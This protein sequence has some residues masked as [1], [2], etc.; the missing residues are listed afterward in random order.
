M[1]S[2]L[3]S[4]ARVA[5]FVQGIAGALAPLPHIRYLSICWAQELAR[6]LRQ[7]V[8]TAKASE[9]GLAK[10]RQSGAGGATGTAGASGTTASNNDDD[11]FDREYEE[12]A[13]AG[14]ASCMGTPRA[15]Q[16]SFMPGASTTRPPLQDEVDGDTGFS[17]GR[18]VGRV[19]QRM[20]AEGQRAGQR[21][22]GGH[23]PALLPLRDVGEFGS[24][25]GNGGM[26]ITSSCGKVA[27]APVWASSRP[28]GTGS[29]IQPLAGS[30]LGARAQANGGVG[31]GG[32]AALAPALAPAPR[33]P[34]L[35]SLRQG[36]GDTRRISFNGQAAR[37]SMLRMAAEY[38]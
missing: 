4:L 25:S 32:S 2:W 20:G 7:F 27:A 8:K 13:A 15:T 5:S 26:R 18:L 11:D 17:T 29:D 9:A 3:L 12:A 14:G 34:R 21:S 36:E 38:D 37:K 10:G 16:M 1:G 19:D 28:H 35:T 24:D 30:G 31:G 22:G 33:N 6:V 23:P